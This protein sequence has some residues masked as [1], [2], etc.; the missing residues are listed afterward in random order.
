MET[1]VKP[2]TAQHMSVLRKAVLNAGRELQLTQAQL[3]QALGMSESSISRMKSEK[4]QLSESSK[5]SEMALMLVKI[6][7]S[8]DLIFANSKNQI[9]WFHSKNSALHGVPAELILTAEGM[10]NVASYLDAY[11]AGI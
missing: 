4:Y 1:L 3:A 7:R 2:A 6:Y 9:D 8:L 5:D 11:R 10:V